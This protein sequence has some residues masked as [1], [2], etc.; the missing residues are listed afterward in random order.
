LESF[1][2]FSIAGNGG[3]GYITFTYWGP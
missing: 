3:S 1:G 2:F